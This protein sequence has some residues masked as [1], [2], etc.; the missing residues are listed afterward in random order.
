[1]TGSFAA[2]MRNRLLELRS[3]L[4]TDADAGNESSGVVELDQARVG[5]LSRMDAMQAQA[6]SQASDRRREVMLQNISAAL[7]RIDRDEYG[8]CSACDE[9]ID[10]KRLEF[11]PTAALCI[12][13]A[14]AAEK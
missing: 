5:R 7:V 13:C 8:D 11:D 14:S 1:M 12:Q 3:K 6:M 9:P 2:T 10:R 4:E